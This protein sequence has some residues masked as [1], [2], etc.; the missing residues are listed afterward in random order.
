MS[1]ISGERSEYLLPTTHPLLRWERI[2]LVAGLIALAL[3]VLGLA[4]DREQFF[5]SWLIS[6]LYWLGPA[7]GSMG[8]LMLQY[9][10]GGRWGVALR[11]TLEAG[12]RTLPFLAICF[13]PVVFG[14][15]ELF[16]WTHPEAV[17]HDPLLQHKSFYLNR[18]FFLVR[19][20]LYFALWIAVATYLSRW[21]VQQDGD[22]SPRVERRLHFMSRAGLAIYALTMTFASVDWAM[23][24]EPH[25]FSHIYGVIFIGGQILTAMMFAVFVATRLAEVPSVGEFVD[26]DR[27]H[28]F[29]KLLLAFIML[30]AYFA[31]SQFL[32]IWSANLPE[33]TP[34][35]LARR[36]GGWQY[37][38]IALVV[39]HFVAPFV[40]LLSR[41]A[42]RTRS[43]LGTLV[44]GLLFMRFVDIY[45]LV[46][47]SFQP[48][49]LSPHWL[50]ATT[51]IAIGGL[52]LALFVRFLRQHPV[53]P[54]NDAYYQ[55]SE[56]EEEAA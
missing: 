44:L 51:M 48:D 33:E 49:E 24:L 11:R 34:W 14:M 25:W 29:G 39:F 40:V 35:Y 30:W 41:E 12:M 6:Y 2:G 9:I 7:L 19:A 8:I 42:K 36:S 32:I 10:T 18:E 56:L 50:D 27:F 38:A 16:E 17:A 26:A 31:L 46:A 1:K 52:W 13:L 15:H 53:L 28:D 45:W 54:L 43:V 37:L 20:V 55:L 21:S 47:P 3:S 5:R 4:V 22:P 23:S